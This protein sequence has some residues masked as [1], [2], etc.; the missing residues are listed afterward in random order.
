[1]YDYWYYYEVDSIDLAETH[2]NEEGAL[3]ADNQIYDTENHQTTGCA[4]RNDG[5]TVAA[6]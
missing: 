5:R 6:H 1:M 4:S 3:G 2:E